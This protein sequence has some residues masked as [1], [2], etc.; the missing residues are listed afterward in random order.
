MTDD[1]CGLKLQ[2][3]ELPYVENYYV[4]FE[5]YVRDQDGM[6]E[7]E[8]NKVMMNTG[9]VLL[10]IEGEDIEGKSLAEV[11]H[12]IQLKKPDMVQLT[13]LNKSWFNRFNRDAVKVADVPHVR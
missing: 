2:T 3:F 9:D 13:F 1:G 6:S 10:A 7:A 12:L 4:S 5:G 11:L 8:D